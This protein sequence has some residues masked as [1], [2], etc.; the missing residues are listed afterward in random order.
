MLYQ[1]HWCEEHM[2]LLVEPEGEKPAEQ[3][4]ERRCGLLAHI[5]RL[6]D[7]LD[8]NISCREMPPP[9]VIQWGGVQ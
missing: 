7:R 5:A 6:S 2:A 9:W 8:E 3:N 1:L 4:E